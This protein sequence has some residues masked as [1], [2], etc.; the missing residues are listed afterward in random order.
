MSSIS[1][2]FTSS[3]ILL[4]CL[5]LLAACVPVPTPTPTNSIQNIV[6]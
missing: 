3:L 2:T 5:S 4:A 1:H 6:W